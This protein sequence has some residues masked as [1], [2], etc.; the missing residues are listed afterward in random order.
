MLDFLTS[1][2]FFLIFGLL[3]FMALFLLY[4]SEKD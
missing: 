4:N 3:I 1:E 2:T